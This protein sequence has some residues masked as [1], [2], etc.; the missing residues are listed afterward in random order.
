[1]NMLFLQ[2]FAEG[3]V[4][5]ASTPLQSSAPQTFQTTTGKIKY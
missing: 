2:E 1:M 5:W 4:D 3:L